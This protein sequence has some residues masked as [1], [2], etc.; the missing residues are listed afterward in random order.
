MSAFGHL[1]S[2]GRGFG[3]LGGGSG[4]G[5]TGPTIL[6]S[7]ASIEENS[8]E[9]TLVGTL[10]VANGSGSYT[11]TLLDDADGRVKI[12]GDELQAGATPTDYEVAT[13]LDIEVE[14]DNGVDDPITR[15]FT[16]TVTNVLE[17]TLA[18]L[19]LDNADIVTGSAEDTP[20]GALQSLS[21]GSVRS[22]ID[23]AGGRFKL[24][25][26]NIVAGSVATDFDLD[27]SHDITVRETHTDA[28]NSPRDSVIAITVLS[29]AIAPTY[30]IYGF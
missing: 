15:A 16:I 29:D 24:T 11:F 12:D 13:S 19:T 28:S 18:A 23:T 10:S 20:V 6:L 4:G 3:R 21:A 26:T 22:L 7:A 25:G 30:H 9:D 27:T 8:A 17:V 14:A 2:L 5:V 1:G